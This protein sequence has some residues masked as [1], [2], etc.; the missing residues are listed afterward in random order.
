MDIA[1]TLPR[2]NQL[3]RTL[4]RNIAAMQNEI[5]R[6]NIM[7]REETQKISMGTDALLEIIKNSAK[8]YNNQA[9]N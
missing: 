8:M 1:V 3:A 5:T 7:L 6:Q 2:A 9:T 4:R